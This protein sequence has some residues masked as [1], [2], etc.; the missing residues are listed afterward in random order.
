MRALDIFESGRVGLQHQRCS[1]LTPIVTALTTAPFVIILIKWLVV[2]SRYE[3]RY[4]QGACAVA[5][6]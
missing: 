3:V 6:M 5:C 2:L 4:G 1:T